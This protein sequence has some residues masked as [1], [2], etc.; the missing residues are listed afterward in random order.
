[1]G[2]CYTKLTLTEG[3][4]LNDKTLLMLCIHYELYDKESQKKIDDLCQASL[5]RAQ[6]PQP[7]A[8][9]AQQVF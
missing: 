1:M 4:E 6:Q 2:A 7:Q 3:I 9:Q 8:D 5:F